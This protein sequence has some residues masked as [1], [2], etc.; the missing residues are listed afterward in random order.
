[1]TQ[2]TA[3]DEQASKLV[4]YL[5]ET[6]LDGVGP[7]SGAEHLATEYLTTRATRTTTPAWRR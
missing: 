2:R 7:L 3:S 5:L 6:G 1:M 4:T